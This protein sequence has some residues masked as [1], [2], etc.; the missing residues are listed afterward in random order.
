M[1]NHRQ[2]HIYQP[3]LVGCRPAVV[4]ISPAVRV[5]SYTCSF[6]RALARWPYWLAPPDEVALAPARW[7]W[8]EGRGGRDQVA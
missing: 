6:A 2:R 4:L 7:S 1:G 8:G 5:E 3:H